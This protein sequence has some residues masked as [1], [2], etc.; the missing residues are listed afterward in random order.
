VKENMELIFTPERI[1][2]SLQYMEDLIEGRFAKNDLGKARFAENRLSNLFE[3]QMK[4]KGF[5]TVICFCEPSSP[6]FVDELCSV[7]GKVDDFLFWA[8][9]EIDIA[10]RQL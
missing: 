2:E 9:A 6:L 8:K 5:R 1:A 10:T 7:L 4:V 3:S